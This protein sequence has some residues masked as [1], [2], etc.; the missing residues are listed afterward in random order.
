MKDMSFFPEPQLDVIADALVEQGYCI[1]GDALPAALLQQLLSHL[2]QLHDGDLKVAGIGRQTDFQVQQTIRSD[3]IH[4]LEPNTETTAEFLQWMDSLRVGINRRL[5]MGLFD[6]ESHFAHY[7]VGA[8]YKKHRDA[9]RGNRAQGQSNRV[10]S[11][12]LYLND[13]WQSGEG[14]ELLLYAEDDDNKVIESNLPEFGRLV[15][16]LSEKFP[17]EV[18]PAKRERKSIAGWFRVNEA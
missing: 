2:N 15:I 1:V 16:F 8:F 13:A 17:H 7:A 18:L 12:V 4:W 14:G 6:Y 11:T 3:K 9:F 10:L 5:F